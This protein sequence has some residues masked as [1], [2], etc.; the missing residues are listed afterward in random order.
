MNEGKKRTRGDEKLPTPNKKNK[1]NISG[2]VS[3]IG[4]KEVTN[5]KNTDRTIGPFS[6]KTE[7]NASATSSSGSSSSS[8]KSHVTNSSKSNSSISGKNLNELEKLSVAQLSSSL[9]EI[10]PPHEEKT[11]NYSVPPVSSTSSS[12]S[13]VQ[14]VRGNTHVEEKEEKDSISNKKSDRTSG[15]F[16]SVRQERKEPLHPR[17]D[18]R[19]TGISDSERDMTSSRLA[20]EQV[21]EEEEVAEVV[22]AQAS[23]VAATDNIIEIEIDSDGDVDGDT[24]SPFLKD[25]WRRMSLRASPMASVPTNWCQQLQDVA[26]FACKESSVM[27]TLPAGTLP[28]LGNFLLSY[29]FFI[30]IFYRSCSYAFL[31]GS[32]FCTYIAYGE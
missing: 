1:V 11:N 3:I 7:I 13:S 16:S 17:N 26:D 30:T 14:S 23:A 28:L 22:S 32:H 8:L 2:N 9:T 19:N 25:M 10:L 5:V 6:S 31:A 21:S 12:S 15:P 24:T 4:Q 29:Q 20:E 27:P 18:F